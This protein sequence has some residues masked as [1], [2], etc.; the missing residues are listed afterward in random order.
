[1]QYPLRLAT[2]A[3][4]AMALIGCASLPPER[5]YADTSDVVEARLG[6]VPV[7]RPTLDAPIDVP[8]E[9]LSVD[10]AIRVAFLHNPRIQQAYARIGI[11]R[12]ELEEARRIANPTFGYAKLSPR[13]GPGSQITH[14]LSVEFSEILLL[15]T[16][17][18]FAEA[19]LARVQNVVAAE[20]LTLATEV[21]TAWFT[22]VSATLVA[23]MR[24]AVATSA[25]ASADLA[26]RFFDAGNINRL[27]LE[28]ERASSVL[29]RIG[30]VRADAEADRARSDL[31]NL[32][33]LSSH[34]PWATHQRLPAPIAVHMDTDALVASAQ[35][36]RLDLVAAQ[37]AARQREQALGITRRWRWLGSIDVGYARESEVDGGENRGPTLAL[38]LPIFNQ[39]QGALARAQAELLSARSERDALTLA[40]QNGARLALEQLRGRYDVAERY[41]TALLPSREAIVARSQEETNFMLMG[42]FELILA[43]QAEYDAYQEYLEAVRDYWIARAQLKREVGGELPGDAGDPSET[44]GVESILPSAEPPPMDHSMHGM[45]HDAPSDPH[46]GHAMPTAPADDPHAG[47]AMP[48]PSTTPEDPHAGHHMAP[49]NEADDED[50]ENADDPDEHSTHEH[51]EIP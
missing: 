43:K 27:Q 15:S 17:K 8:T 4:V 22:S 49:A 3:V 24:S 29:A 18:R 26:Q 48:M 31:A 5:G 45:T 41:R 50:G 2:S 20:L 35:S 42:V 12:A 25:Q 19:E 40:V 47:H 36:Q 28:Q 21:E 14:S 11:G 10:D 39:G 51:G 7:Y 13:T 23:Q 38:G 44:I 6:I 30:A 1:M 16:R 34:A 32:L 9:P 37:Q 33:G 46:A